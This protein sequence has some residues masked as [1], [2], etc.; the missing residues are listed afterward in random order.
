MRCLGEIARLFVC[1]YW[2]IPCEKTGWNIGASFVVSHVLLS[3]TALIRGELSARAL[4]SYSRRCLRSLSSGLP[5]TYDQ[6]IR[7]PCV[8]LSLQILALDRTSY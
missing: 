8:T 7:L 3:C 6:S 1:A 4:T 2:G 5:Q